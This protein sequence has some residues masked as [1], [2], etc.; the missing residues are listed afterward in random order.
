MMFEESRPFFI[1]SVLDSNH[2]GKTEF[3]TVDNTI[4]EIEK[5]QD[6]P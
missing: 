5:G 4:A 6:A 3:Y 2:T 1:F